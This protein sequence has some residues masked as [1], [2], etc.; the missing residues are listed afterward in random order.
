MVLKA[1]KDQIV[2]FTDLQK[3]YMDILVE[4]YGGVLPHG[5]KTKIARRL[6]CHRKTLSDLDAGVKPGW[7]EEKNRRMRNNIPLL[8]PD[9]MVALLQKLYYDKI[10]SRQAQGLDMTGKDPVDIIDQARRI[11]QGKS[12]VQIKQQQ[13]IVDQS[14]NV[15]LLVSLNEEDL[16]DLI[17]GL[18]NRLRN[19]NVQQ[20]AD[21]GE[22]VD[23]T[24]EY[25]AVSPAGL[26]QSSG[27][28]DSFE[29]GRARTGETTSIEG[30]SQAQE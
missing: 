4:E 23:G 22:I 20:L 13:N 17:G 1:R 27:N 12:A 8:D 29:E 24:V 26:E 5:A 16:A 3:R 9:Q 18:K 25:A 2:E 10:R 11:Q 15:N 28:A 7:V 21:K 14:T 19:Y 30:E 6:S